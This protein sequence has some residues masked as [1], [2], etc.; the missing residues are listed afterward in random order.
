ML[1]G[2]GSTGAEQIHILFKRLK[3]IE[4]TKINKMKES[5]KD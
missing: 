4:E 1:F 5:K 2:F 3:E